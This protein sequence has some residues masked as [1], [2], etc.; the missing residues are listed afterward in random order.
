MALARLALKNLSQRIPSSSS[1]SSLVG[2][3]RSL[4]EGSLVQR[5]K[6]GDEFLRRFMATT[7]T[8]DLDKASASDNNKKSEGKEVAVKKGGKGLSKLFPWRRGS[9]RGGL[10]RRNVERD[11]VPV[12]STFFG[13]SISPHS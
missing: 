10:W 1:S 13:T 12:P 11:F 8:S 6:F 5:Q 7:T 2:L 4:G 3:H 9:R